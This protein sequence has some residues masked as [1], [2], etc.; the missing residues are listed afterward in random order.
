MTD[1]RI[2]IAPT[3]LD[4]SPTHGASFRYDYGFFEEFGP[5]RKPP[6][7]DNR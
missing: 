4:G 6:F 2:V 1:G 5:L 7:E 3:L